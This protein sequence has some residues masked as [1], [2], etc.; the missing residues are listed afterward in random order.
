M[1]GL[2][3]STIWPSGDGE[4]ARLIRTHEWAATP[5]GGVEGWPERLKLAV[6]MTLDSPQVSALVCGPE[7]IL[8]YNDRAAGLFGE[9]HPAALGRPLP[10]AFP[11]GWATVE[12]FYARAFAGETVTVSGQPLDTSGK[13][14][15]T[16]V[17]DAVLIPVRAGTG[18]VACV[19]MTGV[20]IGARLRVEAVMRE[21]EERF[22]AFVNASSDV[23]YRMSPDWSE[24]RALDGRGFL[25]DTLQP[26]TG[27]MESYIASE[28]QADV[29]AAIAHAIANKT[30]F[31]LE[32]RVRRT[33]GTLGWTRSHAV[34]ILDEDGTIVEWLGAAT[35]VTFQHEAQTALRESEERL[36]HFGEA[37]QDVLWIRDAE[38]LHWTY[39][40]P[41]FETIYGLSRK[42]ALEGDNF[43]NWAD[44]IVP[45]DREEAT[46][47]IRSVGDGRR[48][49][50]E[51]RIRRPLDGEIRWVR[52]TDFPILDATGRVASIGGIGHDV[53]ELKRSAEHQATLLAELQHRVRNTLSVIRSIARRTAA[54]SETVEDYAM[55]LDGRLNAFARVQAAVTRNPTAGIDLEYLIADELNAHTARDGGQVRIKGPPIRLQ[56]KAAET[57]GLAFHELSTN[58]VK[59]GAL[60]NSR[61]RIRIKWEREGTDGDGRLLL[62]WKES[63]VRPASL[64]PERR[65]FGTDL[66]LRTLA[67]ELKGRA[68][69]AIEPDGLRYT[70]ELPLTDKVLAGN[71]A[72][73]P[74]SFGLVRE[75]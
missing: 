50:F 52:N 38:T 46:D 42:E 43:R 35:D 67:Y 57:L 74:R 23:V 21:S 27:W 10:V 62:T 6:E 45:E 12:P 44:L 5:L 31:D 63:G 15:P 17:F 49:T 3:L 1:D 69:H 64:K 19:H 68:E 48:V 56:P 32:H 33:D 40:T 59:H 60:A 30:M 54:T 25:F 28:D 34:P 37:S 47:H 65:G 29:R 16:D 41:A 24:M 61:G 2:S 14:E 9:Q 18:E 26:S 51:Y 73:G 53:T 36:R 7:L 4:M 11:G 72:S 55:E 8:I 13:G 66:L 20:E 71:G 70:L 39:L 75:P 58:A 22:R